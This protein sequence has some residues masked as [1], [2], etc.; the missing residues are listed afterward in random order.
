MSVTTEAQPGYTAATPGR[1]D[2]MRRTGDW[3]LRAPLMPALVFMIIVTQLPFVITVIVSF[4]DWNAYYPDERGFAGVDNFRRVLTDANTR[5]AIWVTVLLTAGVVLI[6]LLLGLGIALLLDRKF[7]GRGAVRTMMITPFLVVPVAAALLWKHALYNPEYGLF[8]GALTWLW[9]LFGSDHP[10]QPDWISNAPL[11]SII[12]ALVWQWTPFMMLILLAGLQGRPLD[13]IEAARID[14]AST[15]QIFRSM[16]LPHLRQYLELAALLG[17]IYVVQ[18]FDAVFVITSGGLGTANLPYAIYTIFYN[19][20]DYGRASA[21]AV[22]TVLGTI[23][24]AT[25]ALRNVSSLFRE[26]TGR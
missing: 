10:P 17:S 9:G 20:H 5:H 3:A 13:V 22:V 25:F 12:F 23:I 2:L 4:M 21:A 15:W 8:N 6:S 16:T 1:G 11:W 14:G 24:I 26:E 19:A 18:T 7:R